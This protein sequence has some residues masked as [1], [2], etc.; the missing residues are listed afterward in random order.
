MSQGE[1]G[2]GLRHRPGGLAAPLW[3]MRTALQIG[4]VMQ[5]IATPPTIEGLPADPEVAAGE[6]RVATVREIM[7]HPL[8]TELGVTA[9]LPPRV[10]QL[11]DLGWLSPSYL[12]G[13]T[14]PEC[15]Q[16]F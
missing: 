6:G 9:Q 2:L 16:S 7:S 3:T 15:H 8:K 12:H 10:R 13:D 5:V 1:N 11:A 14:L 4:Q